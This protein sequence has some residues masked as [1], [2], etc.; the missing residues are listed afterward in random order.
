MLNEKVAEGLKRNDP[1]TSKFCLQQK[2]DNDGYP[3]HPVVRSVNCH[4]ANI[5]KHANYHLQPKVKET[6]SYV[7]GTQDFLKKV[8]KLKEIPEESLLVTLDKKPL[9]I[10]IRNK[11]DIKAVNE[12][13][14]IYKEKTVSTKVIITSLV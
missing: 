11:E 6:P 2:I 1:K 3:G 5:S 10:N 9:Y 12:P 7:K 14:E 4:T 13:Y 8:E